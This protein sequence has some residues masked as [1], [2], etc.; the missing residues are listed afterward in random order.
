MYNGRAGTSVYPSGTRSRSIPS[1]V[2]LRRQR[3][4]PKNQRSTRVPE[5]Y[6]DAPALGYDIWIVCYALLYR[7]TPFSN[8][9]YIL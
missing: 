5:G 3:T 1:A 8:T 7:V 6:T 9:S 4:A 2:V